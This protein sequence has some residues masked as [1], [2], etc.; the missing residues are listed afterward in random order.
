VTDSRGPGLKRGPG[1]HENKRKVDKS[2]ETFLYWALNLKAS[3][4]L[5]LSGPRLPYLVHLNENLQVG[6]GICFTGPGQD[7]DA[8]AGFQGKL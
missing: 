6:R 2:K 8:S 4:A 1:N 7:L 5:K 3:K